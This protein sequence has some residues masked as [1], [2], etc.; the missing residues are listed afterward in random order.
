MIVVIADD[1]QND[2]HILFWIADDGGQLE[3]LF[4]S[5]IDRVVERGSSACALFHDDLSKAVEI[6]REPLHHFRRVVHGHQKSLILMSRDHVVKEIDGRL[7]LKLKAV[8]N[9]VGSIEEQPYT[10]GH[11]RLPVEKAYLLRRV[12]IEN[13]EIF[14]VQVRHNPVLPVKYCKQH[15]HE[16][17]VLAN[18]RRRGIGMLGGPLGRERPRL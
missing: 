6:T 11:I 13:T 16:V 4:A 12:V 14:A 18:G 7:L 8:A 5:L 1:H 17:Y 3:Q 2:K 10:Q 15:I 9:A